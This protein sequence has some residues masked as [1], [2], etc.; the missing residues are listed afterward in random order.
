FRTLTSLVMLSSYAPNTLPPGRD[1]ASPGHVPENVAN[2][3]ICGSAITDV[4][5]LFL[6]FAKLVRLHNLRAAAQHSPRP[7]IAITRPVSPSI[8]RPN[9]TSQRIENIP[10]EIIVNQISNSLTKCA[11]EWLIMKAATASRTEAWRTRQI[12]FMNQH[13]GS[14]DV[15]MLPDAPSCSLR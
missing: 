7:E 9:C 10:V 14:I 4:R 6:A 12:L 5:Q 11:R 8:A 13:I 1:K 2:L 3:R 15:N